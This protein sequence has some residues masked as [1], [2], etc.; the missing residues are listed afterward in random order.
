MFNSYMI[1]TDSY[2]SNMGQKRYSGNA[3][4]FRDEDSRNN[5]GLW[6]ADFVAGS[7][8][9]MHFQSDSTCIELLGPKFLGTGSRNFWF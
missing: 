3:V 4:C 9:R 2:L 8:R 7:F 1:N 6:G 5:S